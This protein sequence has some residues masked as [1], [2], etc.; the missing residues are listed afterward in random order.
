MFVNNAPYAH[1][2]GRTTQNGFGGISASPGAGNGEVLSLLDMTS[3]EY[4]ILATR[5]KRWKVGTYTGTVVATAT[6]NGLV[7][8]L[9]RNPVGSAFQYT[10]VYNG[11]ELGFDSNYDPPRGKIVACGNYVILLPYKKYFDTRA[12]SATQMTAEEFQAAKKEA[13]GFSKSATVNGASHTFEEGE[14]INVTGTL[15]GSAGH[16]SGLYEYGQ[17]KA[18]FI[19]E[20]LGD[21]E[22]EVVLGCKFTPGTIEFQYQTTAE[23]NLYRNEFRAGDAVK[24]SNCLNSEANN[25]TAIIRAV[26]GNTLKFYDNTFSSQNGELEWSETQVTIKRDIPEVD[27]AFAHNNRVWA[28][29]GRNIYCTNQ[30]DPLVWADYDSLSGG[31]WWADTGN[32]E[33]YGITGGVSYGG[34]PRFFSEESIYTVYGDTPADFS[35]YNIIA[36]G[37]PLGESESFAEANGTLYYLSDSGFMAYR[38]SYPQKI[39]TNLRNNRYESAIGVSDGCKYYVSCREY[40]RNS[41]GFIGRHVYVYDIQNGIWHEETTENAVDGFTY[42]NGNI[43]AF[44]GGEI[45]T[46]GTAYQ[47]PG[48]G[49][50]IISPETDIEGKVEFN[51]YTL[52]SVAKKQVKEIIIRHE[53]GVSLTAK[54]FVDGVLD[55]SFT[56]TIP[57]GIKGVTRISGIP[58]RCDRWRLTLEGEAPWRVFSIAYEYYEGSTK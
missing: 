38:G 39:D 14:L 33:V 47:P 26:D 51:D 43:Y 3:D 5:Q 24:I 17:G 23:M 6:V 41:L 7:T 11:R 12:Q 32:S 29:K 22:S 46:M 30:G 40:E 2:Y 13:G 1:N 37:V 54:V 25:K 56:K 55:P 27:I 45:W 21:M 57:A 31:S 53:V 50:G 16:V 15:S 9:L 10:F 48:S 28:A 18:T 4:P 34:Y 49:G 36:K 20:E 42:G 58:K 8:Y 19:G 35:I 44:I 52:D